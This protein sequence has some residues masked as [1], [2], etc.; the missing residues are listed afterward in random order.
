MRPTHHNQS[1]PCSPQLEKSLRASMKT[2][3]SRKL[4]NEITPLFKKDDNCVSSFSSDAETHI[5][6]GGSSGVRHSEEQKRGSAW[7][8]P[9]PVSLF[10]MAPPATSP[11]LVCHQ[12]ACLSVRWIGK[13][14]EEVIGMYVYFIHI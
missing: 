2:Q 10:S 12:W 6:G 4:V 11:G 14:L 9:S 8:P 3:L 5:P 1:R 7:G 13:D